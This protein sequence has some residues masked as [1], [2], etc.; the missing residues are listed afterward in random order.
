M[1]PLTPADHHWAD[2]R[3]NLLHALAHPHR[4]EILLWLTK[5][6]KSFREL[7]L[8]LGIS[9]RSV[10]YSLAELSACNLV[11]K[12]SVGGFMYYTSNVPDFHVFG[13]T[14]K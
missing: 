12:T 3:A 5:G 11:L 4:L 2:K 9:D 13:H 8:A 1:R 14:G 7:A 10:S 6:E